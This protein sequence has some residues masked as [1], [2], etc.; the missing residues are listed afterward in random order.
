MSR[1]IRNT[2]HQ[3]QNRMRLQKGIPNVAELSEG[4]PVLR[5]VPG[6]GIVEYIRYNGQLYSSAFSVQAPIS[7]NVTGNISLLNDGSIGDETFPGTI[8][9][10]INDT[11]GSVQDDLASLASKVNEIIRTLRKSSIIGNDGKFGDTHSV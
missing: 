10:S 2:V 7:S 11:T 4:V 5:S 6:I 9:N 3:K 8:S 1:E